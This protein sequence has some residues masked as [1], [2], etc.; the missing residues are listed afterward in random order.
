MFSLAPGGE[1]APNDGGSAFLYV[2]NTAIDVLDNDQVEEV[3]FTRDEEANLVWASE[4]L[5]TLSDGTQVRN[6][7]G[8]SPPPPPPPP[9]LR[10][11]PGRLQRGTD[12]RPQY[13]SRIVAESW[14]LNEAEVPRTGRAGASHTPVRARQRWRSPIF[15]SADT[16]RP[17]LA[18][19]APGFRFD[20]LEEHTP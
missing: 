11:A 3:L 6:G 17:R 19:P 2:P 16:N 20:Y 12:S 18:A 1:G 15:G 7:D 8:T 13:R 5:V 9:P 14:R 4:R 10:P